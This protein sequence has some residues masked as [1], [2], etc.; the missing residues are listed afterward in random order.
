MTPYTLSP[1][2]A[3]AI[4][5]SRVLSHVRRRL[6]LEPLLRL[7]DGP[8]SNV[9]SRDDRMSLFF[10]P[11]Y[12][13]DD[14]KDDVFT[15]QIRHVFGGLGTGELNLDSVARQFLAFLEGNPGSFL[16]TGAYLGIETVEV[17][18]VEQKTEN[19]RYAYLETMLHLPMPGIH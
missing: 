4:S 2:L 3:G 19:L 6:L 10:H 5:K 15:I 18:T 14:L 8:F 17:E 1:M 7:I 13:Q 11:P 9:V 12:C 16:A